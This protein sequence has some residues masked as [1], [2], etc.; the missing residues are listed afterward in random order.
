[1]DE[2]TKNLE[3]IIMD[4]VRDAVKTKLGG[5]GTP[6]D[7]IINDV[8]SQR[9]SVIAQKMTAALDTVIAGDE[10]ATALQYEFRH[11]VAKT[12]V[13]KM[14]GAVEKAANEVRN[15]PVLKAQL[16]QAFNMIIR[17]SGQCSQP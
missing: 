9:Q 15:N 4:G 8:I 5:Y 7:K 1:M 6:L 16:I 13:S 14:E 2:L 10:F 11:K 12:L 17:E 3:G